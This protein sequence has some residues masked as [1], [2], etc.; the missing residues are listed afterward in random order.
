VIRKTDVPE[1]TCDQ[2]Q[3]FGEAGLDPAR[4]YET[5]YL[6]HRWDYKSVDWF[7]RVLKKNNIPVCQ[8]GKFVRLVRLQ[9]IYDRMLGGVK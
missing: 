9:D 1:T 5:A 3:A 4:L 7:H 8:V 6:A 2:P